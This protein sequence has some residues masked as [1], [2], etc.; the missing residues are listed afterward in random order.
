MKKM[1]DL[2]NKGS[3]HLIITKFD[4]CEKDEKE[5]EKKCT[6]EDNL[7]KATDKIISLE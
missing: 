2:K 3:V 4:E 6:L 5:K 7:T 1:M